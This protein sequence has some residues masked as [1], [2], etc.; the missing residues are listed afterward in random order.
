MCTTLQI[1]DDL[2]SNDVRPTYG[3]LVDD[4]QRSGLPVLPTQVPGVV[5]DL[6]LVNQLR[7]DE[8]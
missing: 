3:L 6:E 4:G 5:V 2:N 7:D 8:Y 1:G